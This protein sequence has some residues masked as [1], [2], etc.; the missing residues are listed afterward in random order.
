MLNKLL[1]YNPI[2]IQCHDNPDADAL[3]S[4]FALYRFFE[5]HGKDVSFI[6]S[7]YNK[8]QKSNLVL[9]QQE[10]KI[11]IK[12]YEKEQQG[13]H[14]PGLLLTVDCQYGAGNVTH[15][16]ADEVA[17]IDHHQ[18][19][20]DDI[21]LSLIQPSLGSCSTLVWD[22]LRRHGWNVNKDQDVG[23][24]LY[25]GLY[26]DTNQF[27]ELH[28]PLDRDAMDILPHN[29]SQITL[30]K[31]SNISFNELEVA[32]AA[33][34]GYRYETTHKYAVI[35]SQPC[36]PNI[37]GLISDFFLQVDGVDSCIVFNENGD[38]YKLSVR[39]C[40]KEI[41]ASDLVAF[42]CDKV[43]S[44]GGHYEKAGGFV[45][46]KLLQEKFANIMIEDY[47]MSRMEQYFESFEI[48]YASSYHADIASMKMYQKKQIP[49]GYVK[50]DEILPLGTPITVRTLEGDFD[51]L[52][53]EDL[54]ILIGVKGEVYTNKKAKF[55]NAYIPEEIPYVFEECVISPDY[56]PQIK[57]RID[58]TTLLLTDYAKRCRP[59]GVVKVFAK[60]LTKGV[61]IF[62]IWDNEHYLTGKVGDYITVRNDDM[63]DVYIVEKVIFSKSYEEW[64]S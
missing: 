5:K 49:I 18:I 58:G 24:A 28:N 4:G 16:S 23:T 39:S 54:Y 8:I 17:I 32:S 63:H 33:M 25:Y 9:M 2:I 13:L 57:N 50:A 11:P 41:N 36:D 26:T 7:G 35:R 20:C 12:Y 48:I 31:N 42:L 3:A 52:V 1:K 56:V 40:I 47:I 29:K 43:G 61:K 60:P 53:E 46:K 44:G 22:L 10:L 64:E 21:E 19:E 37:L 6:Y 30:F 51:L 62:P 38:G 27:S 15:F 34:Q 45:S 14:F 59:A 55:E